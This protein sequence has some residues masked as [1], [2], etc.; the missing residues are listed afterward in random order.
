MHYSFDQKLLILKKIATLLK[1]KTFPNCKFGEDFDLY[2]LKSTDVVVD[3]YACSLFFSK[4]SYEKYNIELLQIWPKYNSFLYFFLVCKIAKKFLGEK[5]L[6]F[7]SVWDKEKILY[8]WSV[9]RDSDQNIVENFY[10]EKE[11]KKSFGDFSFTIV[12]PE[13]INII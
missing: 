13:E 1:F 8:C 6:Y 7:F 12:E 3:G 9:V 11:T 10:G 2:T 4:S 5:G